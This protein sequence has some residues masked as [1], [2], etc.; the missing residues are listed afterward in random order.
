MSRRKSSIINSGALR[1]SRSSIMLTP[2]ERLQNF[3]QTVSSANATVTEK[4]HVVRQNIKK[5]LEKRKRRMQNAQSL[6]QR[7]G[8]MSGINDANLLYGEKP[9]ISST[10]MMMDNR[11]FLQDANTA[12]GEQI[13]PKKDFRYKLKSFKRRAEQKVLE[14]FGK[15]PQRKMKESEFDVLWDKVATQEA[16]WKEL[17]I[18]CK[19]LE[20]MM[21]EIG[22]VGSEISELLVELCQNDDEDGEHSEM[23]KLSTLPLLKLQYSLDIISKDTIPRVL[24][25][26]FHEAVSQPLKDW[27]DDFPSYEA[28]IQKRDGLARDVDAY[29]RKLVALEDKQID[30]RDPAEIA[31]RKDQLARAE[32]R[33]KNFNQVMISHFKEIDAQKYEKGQIIGDGVLE[34]FRLWHET[35]SQLLPPPYTF[36]SM[37]NTP[38]KDSSANSDSGS[39]PAP[40]SVPEVEEVP[41]GVQFRVNPTLD[42]ELMEE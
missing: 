32:R 8:E 20:G 18:R 11:T 35:S 40:P 26:Q 27:K 38:K 14:T 22:N 36:E 7:L 28:C 4:S 23:P 9:P 42:M 33:F 25:N 10:S 2:Q 17:K 37:R 1:A 3:K 34:T 41:S 24:E 5:K 19:K 29:E 31:R 39:L 6:L 15:S 12:D 21:Q 16:V 30:R 13:K